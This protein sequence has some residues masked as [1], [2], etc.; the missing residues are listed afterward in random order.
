MSSTHST[1]THS[2]STH[3]PFSS[4]Q[5][6]LNAEGAPI[7]P[8][9]VGDLIGQDLL[10]LATELADAAGAK[11]EWRFINNA[12]LLAGDE[13]LNAEVI[14]L[15]KACGVALR[16][17]FTTPEGVGNLSPSVALRKTLNLFAGVRY[18]KQLKGLSS[19][20]ED[21]DLDFVVVRENTE[22]VYA[23]LEH[24]VYPGVVESI[25][26]VTEAA[27]K[28]VA[29]F[30]FDLARAQKRRSVSIIHKANIMKRSD[31][32]ILRV[33]KEIGA[34][35]NDV[36]TRALI[37]DNA[38][39]QMVQWPQQFDVVLC[40]NLY[41]DILSDLGAG[42]VGGISGVW[43]EDHGEGV[44]MFEAIHGRVPH[45]IGQD[46]ANPLPM[47]MP[48]VALLERIG[49]SEP[50]AR[51]KGAITTTLT[52]AQHLTRD[53]GGEASTSQMIDAL[54]GAL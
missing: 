26:V 37:V 31:G 51:L 36:E 42:L 48:V 17:P 38:C 19:R 9:L 23:G 27:T 13:E 20:Y 44:V 7:I 18:I 21:L 4:A 1:S 5:L 43:G 47:L 45:M 14:E 29:T 6:S 24:T 54:K 53:L 34:Q 40:G 28:R 16:A 10:P 8:V 30:A 50:A 32:L 22:D 46:C 49:Q 3:T 25:K 11:V 33:S 35:Y 12:E 2:T 15:I 52:H 41:G 39:M